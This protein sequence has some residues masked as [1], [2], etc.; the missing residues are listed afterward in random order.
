MNGPLPAGSRIDSLRIDRVLG[1]GAFGITYLVTDT[2][3]DTPFALKEYFPP[4]LAR[5]AGDGRVEIPTRR[6][7]DL[8]W[9]KDPRRQTI[10]Y[11]VRR[12]RRS[13]V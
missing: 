12:R 4:Q 13:R 5:R 11:I 8:N 10:N 2:V 3:L 1:Q 9:A 6:R 7:N